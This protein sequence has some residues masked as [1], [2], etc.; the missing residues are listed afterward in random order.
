M[1]VIS[2]DGLW[3]MPYE[4]SLV[5]VSGSGQIIKMQPLGETD[6]NYTFAIY[7]SK[8]KAMKVMGFLRNQYLDF[9]CNYHAQSGVFRFP[10]DD[11]VEA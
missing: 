9:C 6:A 10:K 7:T 8:E 1:R 11:E 2:Q 5:Y 3:D 4:R